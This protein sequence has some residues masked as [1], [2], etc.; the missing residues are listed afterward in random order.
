VTTDLGD[1]ALA[2]ASDLIAIDSVNPALV[3]GARGE[4]DI[5]D[6]LADRLRRNG[7]D[8]DIV[9]PPGAPTRPSI[10]AVRDGGPGRTVILNGHVDTV[11]VEGMPEPFLPR[12]VDGRL[13][14]RG[15]CDMKSGVA[16]LVVAAEAVAAGAGPG[17]VVVALVADEEDA[18]LGTISVLAELGR[19]GIV[20]DVCLVGEPTSLDLAVAHRGYALV[21]ASLRGRAA[22]SSR[23]EEGVNAISHLGRLVEAV[24]EA[25]RHLQGREPHPMLG[26]GSLVT[27]VVRGGLAPFSIPAGAEAIVERRTLPGETGETARAEIEAVLAALRD[28]DP[29]VDGTVDVLLERDSWEAQPRGPAAELMTG[30]DD[31]LAGAGAAPPRPVGAPYWMESALWQA[32][33]VPAVVCGPAGGGLHAVDEWVDVAQLRAYPAA[34]AHAVDRFLRGA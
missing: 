14:G 4:A 9:V 33:G 10:L 13:Q 6:H 28:A 12:L 17:R 32:A 27:T 15:A 30:L 7:F 19:R 29:Q 26:H 31:G 8:V 23:P 34:V 21:R 5:C 1:A 24:D 16:G 18:S 2:L 3:P 25:G 22:H 20:G 11:G